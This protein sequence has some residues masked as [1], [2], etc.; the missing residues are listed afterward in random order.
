MSSTLRIIVLV[1]LASGLA[2]CSK[3]EEQSASRS[4]YMGVTPWPAD[5]T[6]PELSKAYQFIN[7]HCDIVSQHL[8]DGIPYQEF[9]SGGIL[10]AEFLHDINTRVNNTPP[11]K[12][13]LLSVSA[14]NLTRKEKAVYYGKSTTPD[15]IK[16]SWE[17]L[18]FNDPK[19]ITAYTNYMNWL[20][21]QFKPLYVNYGVES[22]LLTWDP[23]RFAVYKDFLA[24]VYANLKSAHPNTIF[25]LSFMVDESIEGLNFAKQ[26]LPYTDWIG[27]SSYPYINISTSANGNT[28]PS[29]FPINYFERYI[30]LDATKP[31][32]FAETG[33]L[34]ENLDVLNK[35]GNENWQADYLKRVFALSEQYKATLVIWFCSKDYDAG[36]NTLK[37]LGLYQTLFGFWEDTGLIDEN[38]RPRP[39]FGIW[40]NWLNK[41]KD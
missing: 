39:A 15:S 7:D 17:G 24:A 2:S 6:I 4:F 34:A 10:P 8:D 40:K 32:A 25:F 26:L 19:V 22:N 18:S 30:E 35:L 1:L 38:D 21:D 3:K 12:K 20:I 27:L 29:K 11:G 28:D 41:R 33:Y 36:N 5:F 31:F 14:L 13:V 23:A 37:Q 9:F 16:S